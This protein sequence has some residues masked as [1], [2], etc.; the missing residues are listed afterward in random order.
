[1]KNQFDGEKNQ[2]AKSYQTYIIPYLA[3]KL[4]TIL[5]ERAIRVKIAFSGRC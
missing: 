5:S 3:V 1:M 2:N 4:Y